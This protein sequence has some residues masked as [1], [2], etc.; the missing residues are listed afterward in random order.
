MQFNPSSLA[1]KLANL[2]SKAQMRS[3]LPGF[4]PL[5]CNGWP[6]TEEGDGKVNASHRFSNSSVGLTLLVHPL[7][8][9]LI[10]P[11]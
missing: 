7:S 10:F 4:T 8:L 6:D 9:L 11:M 1:H 2:S 3:S 5:H